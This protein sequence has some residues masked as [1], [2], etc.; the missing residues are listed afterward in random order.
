MG[1]SNSG[2]YS[3]VVSNFIHLIMDK[4]IALQHIQGKYAAESIKIGVKRKN[5]SKVRDAAPLSPLRLHGM[6]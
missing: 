6:S 1:R 4:H 3:S 5:T 2:K